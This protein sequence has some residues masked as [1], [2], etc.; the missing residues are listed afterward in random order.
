MKYFVLNE[1]AK[2]SKTHRESNHER[3]TYYTE[4]YNLKI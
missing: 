4:E 3:V 1:V 2:K